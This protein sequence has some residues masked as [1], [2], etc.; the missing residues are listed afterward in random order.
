MSRSQPPRG[1]LNTDSRVGMVLLI[2]LSLARH[3]R[4]SSVVVDIVEP[5][6][7]PTCLG[8]ALVPLGTGRNC[9]K[10]LKMGN[11]TGAERAAFICLEKIQFPA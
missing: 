9:S 11:A 10:L 2:R 3:S 4:K 6:G 8:R 1:A 5:A 7:K